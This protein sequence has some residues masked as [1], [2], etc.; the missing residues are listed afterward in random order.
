VRE[1][2]ALR[3]FA[4]EWRAF[5]AGLDKAERQRPKL[6]LAFLGVLAFPALFSA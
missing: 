5:L 1:R 4:R 2:A 3:L 6:E